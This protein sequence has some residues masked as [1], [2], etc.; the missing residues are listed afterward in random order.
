V[1]QLMDLGPIVLESS[2]FGRI[3]N[4]PLDVGPF[5]LLTVVDDI[6]TINA[7]LSIVKQ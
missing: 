4:N 7:A 6:A 5:K 3:F 1:G 2:M